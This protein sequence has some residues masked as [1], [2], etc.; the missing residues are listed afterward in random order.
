MTVTTEERTH[1][2]TLHAMDSSGDTR[3]MWDKGNRD[4][5]EAARKTFDE[6]K[7]KGYAAFRAEG[8]DGHQGSQLRKFDADA[9]RIIMVKQLVGG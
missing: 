9:E 5:V 7:A 1:T 8:K 4:E 2:G 6:L 3:I